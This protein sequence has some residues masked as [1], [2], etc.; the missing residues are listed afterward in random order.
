MYSVKQVAIKLYLDD[1]DNRL[2]YWLST[3]TCN[4]L[5]TSTC[6]AIYTENTKRVSNDA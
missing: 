4:C 5:L 6:V 1:I 2:Y 3:C